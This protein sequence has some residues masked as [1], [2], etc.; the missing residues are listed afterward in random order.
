MSDPSPTSVEPQ[1]AS[2]ST[3]ATSGAQLLFD[4]LLS[5]RFTYVAILGFLVL[6]AFSIMGLERYLQRHF[7]EVIA[8]QVTITDFRSSVVTK[9]QRRVDYSI[10]NSLWVALGGV[11]VAPVVIGKDGTTWI[12]VAGYQSTPPPTRL[13]M[14]SLIEEAERL[15]PATAYVTVSVPHNALISNFVLV[16]YAGALI[17]ILWLRNRSLAKRESALLQ[18]A[19][20]DYRT[21]EERARGIESELEQMRAELHTLEPSDPEQQNEVVSL[22]NERR[23]LE[24]KLASLEARETELRGRAAKAGEL[25]TEIQALEDLLEEA[26]DDIASRDQQI[27]Q[28]EKRLK[29]A[30]K[31]AGALESA[32]SRESE[33]LS[34]RYGTLYRNL[35]VDARALDDMVALRDEPMK[36]KCEEKLKRLNDEA[37]N[38]AVRRKVGGLP[39]HLTIFEIGFAGKG[40]IYY[41]KGKQRRFR[42]LNVG[43]KNTQNAA[44]EYLRKL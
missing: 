1:D 33:Q 22:L 30:A 20:A 16:L 15:L 6:Y 8:E 42:V 36:L 39:P 37:D 21:A 11:E 35:E 29:R 19:V 24:G 28:L 23:T 14:E 25:G 27:Q 41:M 4:R 40:R 7:E 31:D 32:R 12:Y 38:V 10:G 26:S 34:R 13:T 18:G 17:Q 43:A 5:F 2:S 3:P 44:I 9:I